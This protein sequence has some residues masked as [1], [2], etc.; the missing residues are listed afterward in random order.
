MAIP[1]G[2]AVGYQTCY[3]Y[4]Q[5][6]TNVHLIH[7]CFEVLKLYPPTFEPSLVQLFIYFIVFSCIIINL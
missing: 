4:L 5:L 2:L 1:L 7:Y 6:R 3:A